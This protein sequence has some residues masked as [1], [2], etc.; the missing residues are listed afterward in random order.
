MGLTFDLEF[1][2]FFGLGEDGVAALVFRD[3]VLLQPAATRVFV[4]VCRH[5]GGGIESIL[6]ELLI[7]VYRYVCA[8][9]RP[10][11][12]TNPVCTYRYKGRR[13]GPWPLAGRWL[14]EKRTA[15]DVA[16]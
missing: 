14:K 2:I 1:Q 16:H 8:L 5:A 12:N 7:A 3:H 15:W 4:K 11:R 9:H 6:D 13:F 10:H